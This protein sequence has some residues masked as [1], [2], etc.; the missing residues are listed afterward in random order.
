MDR[1]DDLTDSKDRDANDDGDSVND[2]EHRPAGQI[3]IHAEP[4]KQL[5]TIDET[6]TMSAALFSVLDQ[7]IKLK[8]R[9]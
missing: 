7:R 1:T 2:R 9:L 3:V 6:A 4:V 8:L 5:F